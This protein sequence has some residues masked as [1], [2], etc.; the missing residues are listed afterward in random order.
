M[1]PPRSVVIEF[2]S[3]SEEE[4]DNTMHQALH[5][6]ACIIYMLFPGLNQSMLA[7]VCI[8]R[9]DGGLTKKKKRNEMKIKNKI[10]KNL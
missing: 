3:N 1:T 6:L 9:F 7:G 10:K 5:F 4:L 8:E 2:T